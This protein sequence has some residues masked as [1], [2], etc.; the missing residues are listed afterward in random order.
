MQC[1]VLRGREMKRAGTREVSR[2]S[3][4][5]GTSWDEGDDGDDLG[6]LGHYAR[7]LL[8]VWSGDVDVELFRGGEG[9]DERHETG[10]G[11]AVVVHHEDVHAAVARGHHGRGTTGR[12]SGTEQRRISISVP[13]RNLARGGEVE[14]R[15]PRRAS[16]SVRGGTRGDP[17]GLPRVRVGVSARREETS[18]RGAQCRPRGLSVIFQCLPE[19]GRTPTRIRLRISRQKM[20]RGRPS[21]RSRLQISPGHIPGR[22]NLPSSSRNGADIPLLR[23]AARSRGIKKNL[24][25]VASM[26]ENLHRLLKCVSP[27]APR[28]R[29]RRLNL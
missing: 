17:N 2:R 1:D 19:A 29:A 20:I 26:N 23:R 3:A 6:R 10:G 22:R 16:G 9:L 4:R 25:T 27:T 21:V 8:R 13:G 14:S 11:D 18:A 12:R 28:A 7:G 5:T 15:L 24:T